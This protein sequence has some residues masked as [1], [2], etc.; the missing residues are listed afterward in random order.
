LYCRK[1]LLW[2]TMCRNGPAAAQLGSRFASTSA[3]VLAHIDGLGSEF[4]PIACGTN[5]S[6]SSAAWHAHVDAHETMQEMAAYIRRSRV[7]CGNA[8]DVKRGA[9]RRAACLGT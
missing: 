5:L 2:S 8:V 9:W 3:R 1:L 7:P 4:Q 6:E